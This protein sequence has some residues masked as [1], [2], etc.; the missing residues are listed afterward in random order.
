[1]ARAAGVDPSHLSA[2][3]RGTREASLAVLTAVAQVLGLDVSIRLFAATGPAI[4]DRHQA[5]I[6]EALIG[7]VGPRW[8][9]HVEVPVRQPVRGVVDVVLVR[10]DLI[11]A[12]EVHSEVR[13]VEQII[14]WSQ[15]KAEALPSADIWPQLARFGSPRIERLLVVRS[16]RAN[17]DVVDAHR[18][19][20]DAAFHATTAS[21]IAALRGDAPWPGP[22]LLWAG[23]T[24]GRATIATR[25][26]GRNA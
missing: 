2:V 24:A 16:T 10:D 25:G 26:S 20:F 19:T 9:S 22:A 21:V 14:R 17:R 1:V 12:V 15:A 23:A 7:S 5:P 3:E 6:V 4:R 8:R 18:K 13:S 11:V